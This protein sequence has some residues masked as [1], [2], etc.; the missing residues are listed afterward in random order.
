MHTNRGIIEMSVFI[1]TLGCRF[2]YE[3]YKS[4]NVCK[5]IRIRV[6]IIEIVSF[7]FKRVASLEDRVRSKR[8]AL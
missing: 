3:S 5:T 8:N 6:F 4:I 2:F 7:V 1:V